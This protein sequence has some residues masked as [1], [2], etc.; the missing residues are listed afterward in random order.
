MTWQRMLQVIHISIS[1][2]CIK[3]DLIKDDLY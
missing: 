1:T 3:C 2:I